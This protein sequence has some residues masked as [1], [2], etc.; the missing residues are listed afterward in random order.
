VLGREKLNYA[1]QDIANLQEQVRNLQAEL[2]SARESSVSQI[3]LV[4]IHSRITFVE[5]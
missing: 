5:A 1:Q 4:L 2:A 3:K